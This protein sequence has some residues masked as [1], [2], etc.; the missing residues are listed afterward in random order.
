MGVILI[1]HIVR[2]DCQTADEV[3][4]EVIV[5]AASV[6]GVSPTEMPATVAGMAKIGVERPAKGTGSP[7]IG[8]SP[9]CPS[10]MD[11]RPSV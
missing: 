7:V 11:S 8:V 1:G 6:D 3:V 4:L 10:N 2:D 5:A 9:V